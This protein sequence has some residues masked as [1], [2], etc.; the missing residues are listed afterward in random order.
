[1]IVIQSTIELAVQVHWVAAVTVM[2]PVVL[3]ELIER[4][5]GESWY[6][7]GG[8]AWLTIKV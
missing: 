6:V 8:P 5:V 2:L 4:F 7:Q 1:V 3:C